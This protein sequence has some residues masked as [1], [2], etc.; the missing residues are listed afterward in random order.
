MSGSLF[1]FAAAVGATLLYFYWKSK[2]STIAK[3]IDL[4]PGPP[5]IPFLGTFMDAKGT[6]FVVHQLVID[7]HNYLKYQ[8]H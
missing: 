3:T 8:Q 5:K 7:S 2:Y 4:I 6:P 1:L